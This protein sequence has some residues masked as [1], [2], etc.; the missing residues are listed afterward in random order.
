MNPEFKAGDEVTFNA[1]DEPIKATVRGI[2]IK[3]G[4][5]YYQLRADCVRKP[6]GIGFTKSLVSETTGRSIQESYLFAQPS[7]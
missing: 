4:D 7:S 6:S 3:D 2:K 1:Y 5:I